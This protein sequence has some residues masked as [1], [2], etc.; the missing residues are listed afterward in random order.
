[1]PGSGLIQRYDAAARKTAATLVR[2][3]IAEQLAES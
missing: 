2:S 1:M 3:R